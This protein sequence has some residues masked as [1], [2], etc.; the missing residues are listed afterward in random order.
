MKEKKFINKDTIWMILL[1]VLTIIMIGV[2]VK[3]IQEDSKKPKQNPYKLEGTY[4]LKSLERTSKTEG[5]FVLGSGCIK[6]TVVYY[7]YVENKNGDCVLKEYTAKDT[8]I[9]EMDDNSKQPYVEVW[10]EKKPPYNTVY[11]LFVPKGTIK[12]EYNAALKKIIE[13]R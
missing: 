1:I 6:D 9:H 5:H 10:T 11:R 13:E 2:M 12:T 3:D 4:K 7:V 8:L